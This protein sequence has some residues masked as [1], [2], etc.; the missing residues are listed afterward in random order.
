MNIRRMVAMAATS[1]VA[2]VATLVVTQVPANADLSPNLVPLNTPRALI[3]FNSN[4]CFQPT[5]LSNQS[6]FWDGVLVQQRQCVGPPPDRWIIT[7]AG[8]MST[9][10]CSWWEVFCNDDFPAYRIFNAATGKCL[11]V[12]DGSMADWAPVQQWTC[13]DGARSMHWR[14]F[15]G[16]YSNTYQFINFKS[17]LALDVAGASTADFAQLQQWHW[18]DHNVAQN[19]FLS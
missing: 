13:T 19:F 7:Y 1:V 15:F 2:V 3:N 12:R 4:K 5:P 18:T 16:Q 10:E 6:F 17:G 8:E 11:D 9:R 14:I